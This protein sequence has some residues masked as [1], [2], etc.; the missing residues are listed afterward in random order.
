VTLTTNINHL[1]VGYTS[2]LS[3]AETF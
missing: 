3:N 2:N 1:T